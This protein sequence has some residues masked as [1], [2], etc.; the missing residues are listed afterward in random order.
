[1]TFYRLS[2]VLAVGLTV[3]FCGLPFLFIWGFPWL[4]VAGFV[5]TAPC[6]IIIFWMAVLGIEP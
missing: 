3:I 2:V 4:V 6:L 5:I 1:M